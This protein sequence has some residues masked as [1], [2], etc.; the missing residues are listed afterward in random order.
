MIVLRGRA[1]ER[2]PPDIYLLDDLVLRERGIRRRAGEAI[3]VHDDE[4]DEPY[5]VLLGL[6][7]VAALV[8]IGENAA[9]DLRME[10]LHAPVHD[11]RKSRHVADLANGHPRRRYRPRRASR[12]DDLHAATRELADE[13]IESALVRDAHERPSD[14]CIHHRRLSM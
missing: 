2:R 1:D 11:L 4:V 9:V 8:A 12:G 7:D 14:C 6:L 13:G 3:E 5:A 10:R